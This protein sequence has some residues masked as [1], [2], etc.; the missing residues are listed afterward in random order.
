MGIFDKPDFEQLLKD[1]DWPRLVHYANYVK[2]PA[3]SAE[4]TTIVSREV[5][6]LVQY[7]YETALWTQKNSG[8]RGR[9][10]PKRGHPADQRRRL[11]FSAAS[12]PTPSGPSWTP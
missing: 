2:E 11:S 8:N 7:L 12:A 9:R 5:P 4:A 3:L 1:D 10:L 6:R